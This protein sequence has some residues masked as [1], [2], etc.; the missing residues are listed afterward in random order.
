MRNEANLNSFCK[1]SLNLN[2]V[3]GS[4]GRDPFMIII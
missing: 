1:L 4:L 3:K 2:K